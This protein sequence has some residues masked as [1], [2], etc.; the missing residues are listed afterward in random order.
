[1]IVIVIVI[2][3][4]VIWN[5]ILYCNSIVRVVSGIAIVLS[6]RGS[7]NIIA[8]YCSQYNFLFFHICGAK[9]ENQHIFKKVM[10]VCKVMRKRHALFCCFFS[11]F[12]G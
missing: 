7:Y 5:N 3:I 4:V 12:Y 6:G 10:F 11:V 2:V 9:L 1:M 8:I